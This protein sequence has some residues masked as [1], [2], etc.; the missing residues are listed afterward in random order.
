MLD[1]LKS[2]F[3]SEAGSFGFIFAILAAL[4]F[5]VFKSGSIFEK[6][7]SVD[8]LNENVDKIKTDLNEVRA[9]ITVFRDQSN[10]FVQRQSPVSLTPLGKEVYDDLNINRIVDQNWSTCLSKILAKIDGSSNPYDI[11]TA[12]FSIG[13][14]YSHIISD[15]ELAEIKTYAFKKGYN[16]SDFDLIFGVTI[17]DKYFKEKKISIEEV[18]KHDPNKKED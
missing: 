11:Q 16:L 4:F 12:C 2:I 6:F 5:I 1:I 7:K 18:D 9:F 3:T 10:Q 17:R 8:K 14:K 15:A 13:K